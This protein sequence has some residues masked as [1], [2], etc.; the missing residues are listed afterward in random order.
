MVEDKKLW[1]R[2]LV[3]MELGMSKANFTTWLK[4]TCI[5]KQEDGVVYLS[6]PNAFVKDWLTNKFH[7]PILKALRDFGE[8][9]RSV[10]YI[11]TKELKKKDE[12]LKKL[13]A[14]NNELPL[15]EHY[16][17]KEDNLNQRYTFDSF[18]IGPF[19][20]IAYAAAQA[21]IKKPGTA[22]NPLFI[23]GNTGHGKT[24]LI[25]SIGNYIKNH[26]PSKKVHYVTSEKYVV[27]YVG[28]M[29]TNKINQFKDKYKKYDVLIMDDIQFLSNKEKSQEE[30]FHLFNNLYEDNKQIVFSS[31]KHPNFIPNLE[32]RLKSR[33]SQGMIVDI[34]APDHESR[35]AI[36]KTKA[37]QNNFHLEE[38]IIHLLAS[39]LESNIR[40]LEG[41]LNAVICQSQVKGKDLSVMEIKNII[42]ASVKPK[43]TVSAND[44]IKVVAN[45][46]NI[47]EDVIY[48]KTRRKEVVRPRQIAM[49][50]LREDCNVSY[51]SIGQKLGGRDHTTVIHS[52]EKIKDG[53]KNDTSL[54]E[55][56]TQ[57]RSML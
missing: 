51:P 34:P 14:F 44:I 42:K 32:D 28:S 40:E 2:V 17:N 31:D 36:L 45:Y 29:Q 54:M 16:I 37:R 30:L 57:I 53:L 18:V 35:A 39:E 21:V 5:I 48:N 6:V 24:H 8:N 27:D 38:D 41:I 56:I 3:E 47:E 46:Y 23:Y 55:D 10:E 1:D 52:C 15:S 43:K 26:Y 9:I 50:I 25:Q 33:F 13:A 19:N 49:Y 11:V 22:Y 20:E 4:D 7:K 12:G